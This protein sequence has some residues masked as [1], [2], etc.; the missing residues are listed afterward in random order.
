MNPSLSPQAVDPRDAR[1][2]A[3]LATL[4]VRARGDMAAAVRARI[5]AEDT[6]PDAATL[7]SLG[8]GGRVIDAVDLSVDALLAAAPVQPSPGF[9]TRTVDACLDSPVRARRR[10][11]NIL[12]FP[13]PR[14]VN[15]VG[16]FAAI[17]AVAFLAPFQSSFNSQPQAVIA[18]GGPMSDDQLRAEWAMLA[19]SDDLDGVEALLDDSTLLVLRLLTEDQP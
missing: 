12:L 18:T 16:A 4:P 5:A 2:D 10:P 11:S 8:E 15:A 7:R 19:W 14:W 6:L 1:L 17:L 9:T 13:A 3:L